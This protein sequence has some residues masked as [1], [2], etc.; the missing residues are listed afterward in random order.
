MTSIGKLS[1]IKTSW[2]LLGFSALAFELAA[3]YF[4]YQLELWPCIMC[5]YQRVAM[6][7][8]MFAGFI[9][10]V[11]P[12][13]ALVRLLGFS[14]WGVSAVW[15][16]LIAI[17]HVQ[18]QTNTDPFAFSACERVPNLPDWFAL[19]QWFPA[20]FEA[21]GDC[22]GVD[23]QFL[24]L[25]MPMWMVVAFAAYS[26]AFLVVLCARVIKEKSI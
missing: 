23:W 15:G 1:T 4:Q 12:N 25:S 10:A 2:M 7:G 9:T 17:E 5:V 26:L 22:N 6:M 18:I 20:I 13:I 19:H 3:L 8:V 16:L 21:G 11:A 24:G 14:L